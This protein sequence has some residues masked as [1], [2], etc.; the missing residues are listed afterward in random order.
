[1]VKYKLTNKAVEDLTGIWEYT[2]EKWSEEQFGQG[3]G[4]YYKF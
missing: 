3:S 2:V 1:M 4:L